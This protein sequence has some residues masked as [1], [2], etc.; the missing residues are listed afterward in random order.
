[1]LVV[2]EACP[3]P[4]DSDVQIHRDAHLQWVRER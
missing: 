1:M 2:V 4:K 3:R